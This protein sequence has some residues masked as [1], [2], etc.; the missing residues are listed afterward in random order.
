MT[1]AKL[2]KSR[3]SHPPFRISAAE[4]RSRS[5]VESGFVERNA[6]SISGLSGSRH[7]TFPLPLS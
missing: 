2:Q 3:E 4:G 1:T 6:L 5:H 7:H